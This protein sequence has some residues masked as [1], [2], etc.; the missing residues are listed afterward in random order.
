M[1]VSS[2]DK[3]SNFDIVTVIM[4]FRILNSFDEIMKD[5]K[6]PLNELRHGLCILE[7]FSLN[8]SS[9]SIAVRVN[10]LILT[11]LCCFIVDYYLFGVFLS[12]R[13]RRL[14]TVSRTFVT[15]IL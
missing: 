9:S 10:V 14:A 11:H 13:K 6:K 15:A 12:F 7:K 5:N 2:V 4:S 8:F 3:L 1:D